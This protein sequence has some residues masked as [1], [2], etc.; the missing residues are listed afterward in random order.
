[1]KKLFLAIFILI[2][3][4][5]C[6]LGGWY[7]VKTQSAQK[8]INVKITATNQYNIQWNES[9]SETDKL[10]YMWSGTTTEEFINAWSAEMHQLLEKISNY[11]IEFNI[12]YSAK[13]WTDNSNTFE[14]VYYTFDYTKTEIRAFTNLN[15]PDDEVA[16]FTIIDGEYWYIAGKQ[17]IIDNPSKLAY[18]FLVKFEQVK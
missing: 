16:L 4:G 5:G 14:A 6:G 7:F 3:L 10:N 15:H 12:D 13:M 9:L 1:M 18:R 17:Q 11:T 2:L 8:G